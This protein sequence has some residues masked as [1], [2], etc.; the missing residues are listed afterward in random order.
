MS[1]I[2]LK[3]VDLK[4]IVLTDTYNSY[5]L[6]YNESFKIKGIPFRCHRYITETND[7]FKFYIDIQEKDIL[8]MNDY[9]IS[10][11]SD[12]NGFIKNDEKGKY[13]YFSR[14]HYI[15]DKLDR[16]LNYL[17]LNI[18]HISK[19]NYNTVIHII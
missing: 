17:Y 12:Y 13:I 1:H 19:N 10:M 6:Y 16:D 11:I 14:N 8:K 7:N 18:K 5:K 2:V 9:L 3:S 15:N 4:N